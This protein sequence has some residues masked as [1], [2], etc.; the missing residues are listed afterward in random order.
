MERYIHFENLSLM[1]NLGITILDTT[2]QTLFESSVHGEVS[3]FLK[4]LHGLLDCEESCRISFLYGSYQ[5]RRFGGRYIFFAPSGLTYCAVPLLDEKGKML[6][7]VLAGPF[8]MTSYED[9][10]RYDIQ[11]RYS[12]GAPE[13][14]A[15]SRAVRVIPCIGPRQAH[16]A[17]EHLYFVAASFS[18]HTGLI[19]SVPY[20]TDVFVSA[21]PLEKEDELMSAI[22]R[23]DIHR[24]SSVLGDMLKQMLLHYGGSIEV[25]RSR[26]VE[27]MV[28][29]SRAALKGG[30][31]MNAILGLNY[32]FLREIDSFTSVED[33]VLWLHRVT[34]EFTQH[35]FDF[36][37]AKHM[38]IIYRAVDYIMRN[39]AAKLTLK[40]I[41]EHLRIS[42]QYFS[43]IFK[44]ETGQT[45]GDYITYLRI[46]ESK[47][48]LLTSINIVDIPELVGF[49]GQS[50]FTKIFKKE[51][52]STPGRYRRDN[53]GRV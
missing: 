23:G 37:G 19:E 45:P 50:Y 21:Y 14:E 35:V 30:A 6:S 11:H 34:R 3:S 24:A 16:A 31:D 4:E 26:V 7:G 18:S 10:I 22:S 36:S 47:K 12:L 9:F 38:S 15:L 33:M 32:D 13:I 27:L 5:A 42:Q 53:L 29:L 28:L 43:R 8:I 20:Q 2:G 1:A 49:E 39:Y 25:L 52:G 17:S 51:T 44:E 40:E 46:E 48:L 41:A